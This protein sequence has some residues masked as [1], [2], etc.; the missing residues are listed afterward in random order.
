MVMLTTKAA[1]PSIWPVFDASWHPFPDRSWFMG[2][3]HQLQIQIMLPRN[4]RLSQET[5]DCSPRDCRLLGTAPAKHQRLPQETPTMQAY[6][7]EPWPRNFTNY[8]FKF[9][10]GMPHRTW[11]NNNVCQ[12][13]S[14]SLTSISFQAG[15]V[16]SLGGTRA[17][18]VR[19]IREKVM[20]KG[21]QKS[22]PV[23]P[24]QPP[25]VAHGDWAVTQSFELAPFRLI[26]VMM[27]PDR[28][29]DLRNGTLPTHL[30]DDVPGRTRP[31]IGA[32]EDHVGVGQ[33][34][35]L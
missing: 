19:T 31:Q 16:S 27:C 2:E 15:A 17:R 12:L 24:V 3:E 30:G 5:G 4:T 25:R 1:R 9:T 18:V 29:S 7:W 22:I 33:T 6:C 32:L 35:G 23:N 8:T 21:L 34:E 28:H 14:W 26:W 10:Y 20:G 11:S 13:A